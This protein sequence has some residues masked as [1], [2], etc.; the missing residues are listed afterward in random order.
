MQTRGRCLIVDEMHPGIIP[1]LESIGYTGDYFPNISK[2]EVLKIIHKYNGLIVRSKLTIN[3][4]ILEPAKNLKFIARAGA[5]LDQID[6]DEVNKRK[7][8]LFNA[9]EGNRD[10]VAEHTVGLILCLLNKI[11]SADLEIRNGLWRRN[12]NRGVELMGKTVSIIGYGFMGQA[13]AKRL[14][15]FNCNIFAFDKYKSDFSTN[16]VT[17]ATMEQIFDQTDILSLHIPLTQETRNLVDFS[18]LKKFKK[19]IYL[20][21]TARG[22]LVS[23]KTLREGL[24]KGLLLGA[25]LDVLENEKI[26]S[27][28]T[29]QNENLSYIFKSN[30]VLFTPHVAGWSLESYVKINEVL[31]EKIASASLI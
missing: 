10:A 31:V 29:D 2:E 16:F 4:E 9:P 24:E 5:G 26:S 3:K 11:H 30:K 12:E 21:N 1:L 20:I 8:L 15:A 18:F 22:E 17:E 19:P 25:G 7:I 13:F 14:A 6:I 28:N 23:F 27:L